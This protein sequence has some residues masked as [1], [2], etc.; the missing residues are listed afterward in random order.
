VIHI[1]EQFHVRR[2]HLTNQLHAMVDIFAEITGVPLSS[3]G[4][5]RAY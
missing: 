3:D 1:K 4:C 2:T 5:H